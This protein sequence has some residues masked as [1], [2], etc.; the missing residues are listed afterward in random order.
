M[1]SYNMVT[2]FLKE[3]IAVVARWLARVRFDSGL[4]LRPVASGRR[5]VLG[6]GLWRMMLCC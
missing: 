1:W 6:Y 4:N 2:V 3:I 5:P